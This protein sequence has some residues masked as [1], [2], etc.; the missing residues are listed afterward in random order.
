MSNVS[1][2]EEWDG[3]KF[4]PITSAKDKEVLSR[5]TIQILQRL[6]PGNEGIAH[7]DD[8]RTHSSNDTVLL[9][10]LETWESLPEEQRTWVKI[11]AEGFTDG[12]GV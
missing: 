6:F 1:V 7:L 9:L 2:W 3:R 4:V 12:A 5:L 11:Y 8:V 10:A